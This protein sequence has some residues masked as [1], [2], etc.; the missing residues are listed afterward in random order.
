MTAT[1][2]CEIGAGTH[3]ADCL[4]VGENGC[5]LKS[6]KDQADAAIHSYCS[7]IYMDVSPFFF[8]RDAEQYVRLVEMQQSY[9]NHAVLGFKDHRFQ[10]ELRTSD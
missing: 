4:M 5:F 9:V 8:G 2:W 1:V 3:G 6:R 7:R 10:R